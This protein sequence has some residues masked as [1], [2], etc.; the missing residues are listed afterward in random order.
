VQAFTDASYFNLVSA[1]VG[2]PKFLIMAWLELKET[3]TVCVVGLDFVIQFAF[4]SFHV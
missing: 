2:R 4:I 3:A 1:V